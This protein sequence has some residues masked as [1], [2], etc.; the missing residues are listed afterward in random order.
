MIKPAFF[1]LPALLLTT[2]LSA[3]ASQVVYHTSRDATMQCVSGSSLMLR[4]APSTAVQF[5]IHIS[6]GSLLVIENGS[7]I[8]L[9]L[10]DLGAIHL[11]DLAAHCT[12]TSCYYASNG[13]QADDS[14]TIKWAPKPSTGYNTYLTS[15]SVRS[16]TAQVVPAPVIRCV[17]EVPLQRAV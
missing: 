6:A 16:R 14:L 17:G 1:V 9:S 10:G 12:Q 13:K 11:S 7:D 8:V 4:D 3:Q 5:S 2:A 15:L